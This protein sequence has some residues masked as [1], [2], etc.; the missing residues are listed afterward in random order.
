MWGACGSFCIYLMEKFETFP[1]VK[2]KL[3]KLKN[4]AFHIKRFV[5][6][7]QHICVC[8]LQLNSTQ[9]CFERLRLEVSL[10]DRESA[11]PS[12][13][14]TKSLFYFTSHH[15]KQRYLNKDVQIFVYPRID[16]YGGC[17]MER[18]QLICD[19]WLIGNGKS[20]SRTLHL[21][22]YEI[23][24]VVTGE[25]ADDSRKLSCVALLPFESIC[26]MRHEQ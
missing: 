20:I 11:N 9:E 8:T 22:C 1:R 7:L 25:I 16:K 15:I 12:S 21:T 2:N 23:K 14:S 10:H 13:P 24:L 26:N 5:F 4:S 17:R 6:M 19:R 3:C 18:S